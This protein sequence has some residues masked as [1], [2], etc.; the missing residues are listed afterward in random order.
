V[1]ENAILMGCQRATCPASTGPFGGTANWDN[2]ICDFQPGGYGIYGSRPFPLSGCANLAAALGTTTAGNTL[3]SSTIAPSTPSLNSTNATDGLQANGPLSQAASIAIG[4]IVAVV[5]LAII[6]VIIGLIVWRRRSGSLTVEV[7][8]G[9]PVAN[10]YER[11]YT[12][13]QQTEDRPSI[14]GGSAF[15]PG[16]K[17][18]VPTNINVAPKKTLPPPPK[19][20]VGPP[21]PKPRSLPVNTLV[22]AKYSQDGVEYKATIV[23]V[24]PTHYL[25]QYVD[26]KDYSEWLPYRDIRK[27]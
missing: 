11:Q 25:V 14:D 1:A 17:P 10:S 16:S 7:S 3:V 26:F 2:V 24:N 27:V 23:E 5:V 19:K 18:L 20:N 13:P 6:G 15:I 22:M 4:V 9:R 21:V 8:L 12:S